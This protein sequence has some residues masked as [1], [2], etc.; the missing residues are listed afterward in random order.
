[1]IKGLGD[2]RNPVSAAGAKQALSALPVFGLREIQSGYSQSDERPR[3][4]L[5]GINSLQPLLNHAASCGD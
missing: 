2:Y 4:L 3:S 5:R 1:M